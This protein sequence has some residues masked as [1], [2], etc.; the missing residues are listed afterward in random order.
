MASGKLHENERVKLGAPAAHLRAM[1]TLL[2]LGGLASAAI[3]GAL[4]GDEW[5]RYLH[6]YLLSFSFFLSIALGALFF[7][8][9]H[10]LVKAYWSVVLRRIAEIL[11]GTFPMLFLLSLVILVP[12]LLGNHGLY[13]WSNES[14]VRADEVLEHKA[15]WLNPAFFSF[16]IAAYFAIW[17]GM[18]VFFSGQSLKQDGD[19]DFAHTASM[20]RWSGLSMIIFSVTTALASFDLLMSLEPHFFSTIFGVYFFAGCVISIYA[21]LALI[22]RALQGSG[23]LTHSITVEHYHDLGKLL[24]AFIFFWGYIAFS[25]FMLIW[26]A[27]LPEETEWFQ[28]RM[29]LSNEHGFGYGWLYLGLLIFHFCVPFVSLL[30]RWTKRLSVNLLGR[31]VPILSLFALWMLAMHWADLYG[32]VMPSY[33]LLREEVPVMNIHPVD[34][35]NFI[36]I[37]GM[38]VAAAAHRAR[39]INLIPIKDPSLGDSLRFHNQ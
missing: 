27:N 22:A 28:P 4:I 32:L 37:G 34:L 14:A 24:F 11:I 31:Q 29:Q 13:I 12:L 3:W 8:V 26:Y 33:S 5:N 23:R 9:L 30:S 6:S 21:S 10:H 35:L 17:I 15:G 38:F 36:G 18:A 25:Q 39:D 7:V 20:R 2:G 19:G 1:G 16:R